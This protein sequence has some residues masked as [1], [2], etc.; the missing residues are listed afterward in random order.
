MPRDVLRF[1]YQLSNSW[2]ICND[3]DNF[4]A[5]D[6]EPGA[7][8]IVFHSAASPEGRAEVREDASDAIARA[9]RADSTLAKVMDDAAGYAVFPSIGKGAVGVGGAYGHGV[10]YQNGVPV[11][12]CDLSQATVG[13]QLGGQKYTEIICFETSGAVQRFK[14]GNFQFDAQATAVALKSG[15]GANAKYRDNVQVFTTDE[16]GLMFE[17]AIGGQKF[18]YEP[19]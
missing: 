4:V 1:K 13:V 11:G 10:L 3:Q 7:L 8:D 5:R 12:Y 16:K 15:A 18:S 19:I 14:Q 2:R 17:A 9:Q 6:T